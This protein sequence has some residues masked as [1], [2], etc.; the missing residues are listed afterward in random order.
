MSTC[1]NRIARAAQRF[2]PPAARDSCPRAPTIP[3]R[4]AWGRP[5]AHR[6]IA[7]VESRSWPNLSGKSIFALGVVIQGTP[8]EPVNDH[9]EETHGANPQDDVMNVSGGRRLRN[10]RSEFLCLY[11][12][13]LLSRQFGDDGGVLGLVGCGN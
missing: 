9:D 3:R 8:K 10:I 12:T 13:L 5:C 7:V 1:P 11:L 2:G 4:P 6:C